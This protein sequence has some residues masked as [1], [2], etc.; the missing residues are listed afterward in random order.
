MDARWL[1]F[2]MVACSSHGT[3]LVHPPSACLQDAPVQVSVDGMREDFGRLELVLRRGYAGFPKAATEQR[4]S[5]IFAEGRARLPSSPVTPREF[6]DLLVEHFRFLDD[7]HVGFWT[8]EAGVRDWRGVGGH[9]QAYVGAMEVR[10]DLAALADGDATLVACEGY[11]LR[12]LL[13]PGLAERGEDL[14]MRPVILAREEPSLR[15]EFARG[16]EHFERDVALSAVS[17]RSPGPR[18]SRE[19]DPPWLR[20]RTLVMSHRASLD[21]FVASAEEVRSAP[22]VVLDL[23][24]A[25][26]G[27]DRFLIQWFAN[28]VDD[29]LRYWD[30]A[31][32]SSEVVLQG[33]LN[34]W[35]CVRASRPPT[36]EAGAA[37]ID[38]RIERA[39][40]ELGDVDAPFWDLRE[41]S[42]P[43]VAEAPS[44]FR[45]RLLLV[46]DRGCQSA[47]E[48]APLLA[49]QIPGAVIVGENT[50]GVMKVGEMRRYRLPRSGINL[51]LGHQAHEDP[52]G[53]FRESY[54]FAPDLWLDGEDTEDDIRRL[55]ACLARE[56]CPIRFR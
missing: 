51:S 39:Q 6:R 47:C 19:N 52:F 27:S 5:Q 32:L 23:R 37:W 36:D 25:G 22:V 49:Q 4:W 56:D 45:G 1:C 13:R 28:L 15:C 24:G 8:Y 33:G 54:G 11:S 2:L 50:Q 30:K 40:R 17:L 20:L 7:N 18:F 3:T 44:P 46:I 9:H 16:E 12:E 26:G 29:D 35:E 42:P 48:T 21:E 53:S 10:D 34:F 41:T 38:A 31:R 55:A 14:V 43:V